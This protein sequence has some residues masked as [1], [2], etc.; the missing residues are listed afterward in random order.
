MWL[1]FKVYYFKAIC[2]HMTIITNNAWRLHT[3]VL[4]SSHS[5]Y[6]AQGRMAYQRL[7]YF[8]IKK[9]MQTKVAMFTYPWV[10]HCL[11]GLDVLFYYIFNYRYQTLD[12]THAL[13]LIKLLLCRLTL[14]LAKKAG[15]K[16]TKAVSEEI[17]EVEKCS[18]LWK[19]K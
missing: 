14:L 3:S 15:L 16:Y 10:W 6:N 5:M 13:A 8:I 7:I 2:D 1:I 19:W 18:V 17:P 12:M 11:L 4:N 9:V